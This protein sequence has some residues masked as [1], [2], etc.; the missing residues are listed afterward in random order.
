MLD[1]GAA[2]T[3]TTTIEMS[4]SHIR[5][6]GA[7]NLLIA[8]SIGAPHA[9]GEPDAL[10]DTV[11]IRILGHTLHATHHK[12][13]DEPHDGREEAE[14]FCGLPTTTGVDGVGGKMPCPDTAAVHFM[15]GVDENT[16]SREPGERN[17]HI[18]CRCSVSDKVSSCATKQGKKTYTARRRSQK[19]K[20][21][22]I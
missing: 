20:V 16:K 3:T 13:G 7:V 9:E 10:A 1:S 17:N 4:D 5:I 22:A 12:S 6:V 19:R 11:R 15:N 21:S 8:I 14:C 2:K 18:N